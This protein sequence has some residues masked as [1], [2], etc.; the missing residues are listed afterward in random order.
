MSKFFMGKGIA[1]IAIYLHAFSALNGIGILVHIES[2][3]ACIATTSV[4]I[5]Q[6]FN[7]ARHII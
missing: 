5:D 3:A 7:I 1:V 6:D 4:V 2:S